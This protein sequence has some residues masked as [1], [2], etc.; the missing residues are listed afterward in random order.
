MRTLSGAS[1][2]NAFMGLRSG[3]G[4]S[5][6]PQA[7]G[8]ALFSFV[9]LLAGGT[10]LVASARLQG[11]ALG[12][13]ASPAEVLE[14]VVLVALGS[15]GAPVGF[16]DGDLTVVPL[17]VILVVGDAVR[18]AARR[19]PA[20]DGVD[21]IVSV[22]LAGPFLALFLAVA[23]FVA[24]AE[25]AEIEVNPA[26]AAAAGLVWGSVFGVAALVRTPADRARRA[27]GRRFGGVDRVPGLGAWLLAMVI[28]GAGA[29]VA[30]LAV[31][32]RSAPLAA[33]E[34]AGLV[35]QMV[36][37][38]PNLAA[39][40]VSLG[41]GAPIEVVGKLAADEG[42]SFSLADWGGG[43][44][45]L[46][47]AAAIFVPLLAGLVM[48]RRMSATDALES[49]LRSL[50]SNAVVFALLAGTGAL[51][52]G[53][54]IGID[55]GAGDQIVGVAPSAPQTLLL[56]LLW[57]AATTALGWASARRTNPRS[58]SEDP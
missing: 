2:D 36:A 58:G 55:V 23:S 43:P 48:G 9:C 24:R 30:V 53:A 45:P 39:A 6:V 11:P 18:R 14:A 52:S 1:D 49:P 29:V 7:F 37:F 54:R 17:G 35:L 34:T 32:F 25:G 4:R 47:A 40:I 20:L 13:G 51:L 38:L 8:M 12:A 27:N 3:S 42:R 41:V 15:T 16:G 50:A 21:A 33:G 26:G 5:V 44:T 56:A 57:A 28:A 31:H 22:L 10:A 46:Y 19:Q